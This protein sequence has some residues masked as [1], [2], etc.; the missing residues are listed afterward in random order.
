MGFKLTVVG[1]SKDAKQT[2]E[3]CIQYIF[4]LKIKALLIQLAT[5]LSKILPNYDFMPFDQAYQHNPNVYKTHINFKITR[6]HMNIR[7]F[8]FCYH[9]SLPDFNESFCKF[10]CASLNRKYFLPFSDMYFFSSSTRL[11]KD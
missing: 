7:P 1:A 2:A 9:V 10:Y 3:Y 6:K 11:N 4:L 5:E 8:S